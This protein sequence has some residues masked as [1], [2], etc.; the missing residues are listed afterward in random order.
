[1]EDNFVSRDFP[2]RSQEPSAVRQMVCR[3]ALSSGSPSDPPLAPAQLHPVIQIRF[4]FVMKVAG[5]L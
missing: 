2:Q 3:W 1:M 4:W 5:H